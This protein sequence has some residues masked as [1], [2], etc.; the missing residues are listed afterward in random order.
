M[1]IHLAALALVIAGD[2]S[3]QTMNATLRED[4]PYFRYSV[5]VPDALSQNGAS[6][7][8]ELELFVS[9]SGDVQIAKTA[10]RASLCDPICWLQGS[11]PQRICLIFQGCP[12]APGTGPGPTLQSPLLVELS[13]PAITTMTAGT[14]TTTTLSIRPIS[15]ERVETPLTYQLEMPPAQ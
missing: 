14:P 15:Q 10:S 9:R 11:P 1:R 4:Q 2:A 5:T 6:L 3:A 7:P 13:A 8:L 12:G